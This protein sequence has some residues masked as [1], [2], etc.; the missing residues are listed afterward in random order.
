MSKR[1]E[2]CNLVEAR[3]H[4]LLHHAIQF[5]HIDQSCHLL[6]LCIY[7]AKH[8]LGHVEILY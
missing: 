4:S 3:L 7:K 5:T 2:S 1:T 8:P 6:G